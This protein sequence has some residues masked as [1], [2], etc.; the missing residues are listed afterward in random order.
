M[1]TTQINTPA[2][3]AVGAIVPYAHVEDV[4]RS[5]AFYQQLGFTKRSSHASH[6]GR[7]IWADAVVAGGRIMFAQASGPIDHAQQAVLFYMYSKDVAGLREH[8]LASGVADGGQISEERGPK[9][10]RSLVF[11]IAHPFYMPAGQLR[12]HDPDGYVIL[13][14]QLA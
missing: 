14:G 6:S 11:E 2:S 1:S 9:P 7:T 10:G 3:C 8:L 13:I 4:E 5:L 12:V